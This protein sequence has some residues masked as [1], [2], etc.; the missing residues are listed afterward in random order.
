MRSAA[1]RESCPGE[2]LDEARTGTPA[3]QQPFGY[4]SEFSLAGEALGGLL[5]AAQDLSAI[6]LGLLK[7]HEEWLSETVEQQSELLLVAKSIDKTLADLADS[8]AAASGG[9]P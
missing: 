6:H 5:E 9:G 3:V 4:P 8:A 7:V 2:E 1:L